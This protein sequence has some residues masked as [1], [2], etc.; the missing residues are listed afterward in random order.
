[1]D[2]QKNPGSP[3]QR[4]LGPDKRQDTSISQPSQLA[5]STASQNPSHALLYIASISVAALISFFAVGSSKGSD[6]STPFP[7]TYALCSRSGAQ[8]Y[9]VDEANPHVQCLAVFDS[10]FVGVGNLG[11]YT[12]RVRIRKFKST[13]R[14][15]RHRGYPGSMDRFRA[16]RGR[17]TPHSL[18]T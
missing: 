11:M 2:P 1:M 15:P 6:T 8:I 9:T 10:Y 14:F 16:F 3:R 4:S 7:S 18:C 12:D 17:F 13:H 5:S